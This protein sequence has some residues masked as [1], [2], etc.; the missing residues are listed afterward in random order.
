MTK[1]G[2]R[3]MKFWILLAIIFGAVLLMSFMRER[4]EPTTN[5]RKPPYDFV[6]RDRIYGMVGQAD[7]EIIRQIFDKM[8]ETAPTGY[9]AQTYGSSDSFGKQFIGD[10]VQSFY[11]R[12]FQ[13]AQTPITEEQIIES[14]PRAATPLGPELD[15]KLKEVI[16]NIQTAYFIT[17]NDVVMVSGSGTDVID[18]V[19]PTGTTAGPTGT[20]AGPTGTTAGPTGTTAGP[21]GTTAGPT[22]PPNGGRSVIGQLVFGP[23]YT[24][25][26]A[27]ISGPEADT[28]GQYPELLGGLGSDRGNSKFM[29][30]QSG[31]LPS[32]A[33]LGSDANSGYLPFSRSPG[34][35]D[36]I[37]DPY[38]LASSY[39]SAS[40]SSKTDPVPFL[41]DFSAFQK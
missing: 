26:G 32:T 10:I 13:D 25:V 7:R 37:A 21:T 2:V 28:I 9:V 12:F 41:T 23:R 33:S 20:T 8:K 6:E 30:S 36:I 22:G 15:E 24:S 34:D 3:I 29:L 16:K 31:A 38:R 4:F 14:L 18:E 1:C 39:S 35:Q 11:M 19:G 17:Q 40:Y 5:I 27:P